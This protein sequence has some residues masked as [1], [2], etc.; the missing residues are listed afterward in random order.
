MTVVVDK[1]FIADPL[2]FNHEPSGTKW[3]Q[4]HYLANDPVAGDTHGAKLSRRGLCKGA[5]TTDI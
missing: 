5:K 4:A 1:K 3:A 2:C